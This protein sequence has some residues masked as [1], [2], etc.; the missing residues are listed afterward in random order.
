[1]QPC[2]RFAAWCA[3]A[4]LAVSLPAA[5]TPLY[6]VTVVAGAG[7]TAYDLNNLGQV[8]GSMASGAATHA[9]LSGDGGPADLGALGGQYAYAASI[10][11]R[12]QVVGNADRGDGL[13]RGFL[14]SGGTMAA[15]P[16]TGMVMAA[17][18][19]NAGTVAGEMTA[20]PTTDPRHAF[21]YANGSYTDLGIFPYGDSSYAAAI[22]GHGDVVGAA[23]T[24]VFGAPNW[25]VNPFLYHGGT[26]T[27]LGNLGG[28]WTGA[29]SI[30]D[31]GQVV[32]YAGLEARGGNLYP[33]TAFLYEHGAMRDL[34]GLVPNPNLDFNSVAR[35]I[36]NLGQIVGRAGVDFGVEHGF[37]YDGGKMTDLN[38]LIDP[39]S[40]WVIREAAAIN[41]ASQ[42]AA[43][44]CREGLCYALRLDLAPAVPEPS[45]L[46]LLGGG[47][48]LLGWRC[49]AGGV[50]P[51]VPRCPG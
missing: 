6:N 26:L 20:S 5:A 35:D 46:L 40:G 7:S 23:T 34:G 43:T 47:L 3:G 41:D 15:L 33:E 10:N 31:N 22:N 39:A 36:N 37:L 49:R 1:M 50:T 11:D 24:Y 51:P 48:A 42:I 27:D 44:G 16:G 4:V 28:I 14:Y 9:F 2:R 45:A 17:G 32:G 12:G 19:N 29:L 13:L 25:P 30:N 38:D 8:V 21:T 18:I